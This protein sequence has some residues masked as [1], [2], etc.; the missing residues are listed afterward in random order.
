[1]KNHLVLFAIVTGL[2]GGIIITGCHGKTDKGKSRLALPVGAMKSRF[3]QGEEEEQ[4]NAKSDSSGSPVYDSTYGTL[5]QHIGYSE[6]KNFAVMRNTISLPDLINFYT[7]TFPSDKPNWRFYFVVENHLVKD[8]VECIAYP[9]KDSADAYAPKNLYLLKGGKFNFIDSANARIAI[10]NYKYWL[11]QSHKCG[12][13][14]D[15]AQLLSLLNQNIDSPPID[16]SQP[17]NYTDFSITFDFGFIDQ[18]DIN[19]PMLKQYSRK[20]PANYFIGICLMMHVNKN[21]VALIDNSIVLTNP[22]H[23]KV[24]EVGSPCPSVCGYLSN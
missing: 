21:G 14:Y 20:V 3:K 11:Q 1:M 7:A 10:N 13:Y 22:F 6:F 17:Q 16:L 19:N 4:F 24:L 12:V 18:Y 8:R 2:L 5:L 9:V 15:W 23:R